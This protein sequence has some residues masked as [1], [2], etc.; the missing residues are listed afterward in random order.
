MKQVLRIVP[1]FDRILHGGDY[2]PD[3]WQRLPDVLEADERLIAQAGLNVVTLGVFAWSSY[4]PREGELDFGWLD[5]AMDA[6]ARIGCNVIL[7]TPSAAQS[8]PGQRPAASPCKIA[9][10]TS[11]AGICS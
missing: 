5:R 6:M 3:Q 1:G 9:G 4:E 10:W 2:N 11:H 7:A 8:T